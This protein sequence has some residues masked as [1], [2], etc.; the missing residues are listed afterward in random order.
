MTN[1]VYYCM[2]NSIQHYKINCIN[3][4]V[5]RPNYN[6]VNSPFQDRQGNLVTESPDGGEVDESENIPDITDEEDKDILSV[7][8]PVR[9]TRLRETARAYGILHEDNKLSV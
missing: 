4:C 8:N 5:G 3:I 2:T 7:N 1:I 6:M 9:A